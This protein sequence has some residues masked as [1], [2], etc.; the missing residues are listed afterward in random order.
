MGDGSEHARRPHA[1]RLHEQLVC[2]CAHMKDLQLLR[3]V[4][5]LRP[6]YKCGC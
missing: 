1:E 6:A 4:M 5:A 3:A 2:V